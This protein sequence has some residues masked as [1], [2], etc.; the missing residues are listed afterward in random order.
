MGIPMPLLARSTAILNRVT[1]RAQLE[2]ASPRFT[3]RI[4][5][6]SKTLGTHFTPQLCAISLVH[7]EGHHLRI[8]FLGEQKRAVMSLAQVILL[9]SKPYYFL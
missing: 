7:I 8:T 9:F 5:A 1:A 3:T 4:A 6:E 2:G